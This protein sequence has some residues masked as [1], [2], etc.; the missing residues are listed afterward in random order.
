MFILRCSLSS[1]FA[2]LYNWVSDNDFIFFSFF[3]IFYLHTEIILHTFFVPLSSHPGNKWPF[4]V[5]WSSEGTHRHT[6]TS[7]PSSPATTPNWYRL[8]VYPYVI[9]RKS[10]ISVY[11]LEIS[12]GNILSR[13]FTNHRLKYIYIYIYVYVYIYTENCSRL[14]S[15]I[16]QMHS[17]RL[18]SST[19]TDLCLNTSQE[20]KPRA[21][22][23][24]H[25]GKRKK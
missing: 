8:I 7:L 6:P 18:N 19:G 4:K 23:T 2:C 20:Q 5:C 17:H 25:S 3:S 13:I 11:C 15:V 9:V 1:W 16:R 24:H 21:M 14:A 12:K 10:L 22:R